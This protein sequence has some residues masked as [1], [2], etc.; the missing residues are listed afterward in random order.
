LAEDLGTWPAEQATVLVDA[1]QQAGITPKARRTREGVEITVEDAKADEAHATLVANM[2]AI[3]RA[4]RS[5]VGE[6]GRRRRGR[7]TPVRGDE[8]LKPPERPLTAQRLIRFGRPLA[9]LVAGLMIAAVMPPP[10]RLVILM[11]TVAAMVWLL[12]RESDHDDPPGGER[13]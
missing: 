13:P 7:T 3:A 2:D 4:A 5:P 11:A 9:I 6:S 1:L 10:V 12:G 8:Q